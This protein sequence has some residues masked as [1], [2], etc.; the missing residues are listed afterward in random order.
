MA[1]GLGGCTLRQ[2]G[3]GIPFP[4]SPYVNRYVTENSKLS[5]L[6]IYHAS[7]G[8]P[9]DAELIFTLH[10]TCGENLLSHMLT[11]QSESYDGPNV[12]TIMPIL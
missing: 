6:T 1:V 11:G 12:V 4:Q 2:Q 3:A 9:I 5:L 8:V 7:L 10:G